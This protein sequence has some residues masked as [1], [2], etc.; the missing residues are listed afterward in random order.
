MYVCAYIHIFTYSCKDIS[1]ENVITYVIYIITKICL[2]PL[3]LLRNGFT[4]VYGSLQLLFGATF[5]KYSILEIYV[6]LAT[7]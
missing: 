6:A 2:I 4:G 5:P 3:V 7:Q 1:R